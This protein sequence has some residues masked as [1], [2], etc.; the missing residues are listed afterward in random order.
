LATDDFGSLTID[1]RTVVRCAKTRSAK[2]FIESF[3]HGLR[4]A[5]QDAQGLQ[6]PGC[7]TP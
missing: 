7:F 2:E 3:E 4:F 1:R 6:Q 5:P